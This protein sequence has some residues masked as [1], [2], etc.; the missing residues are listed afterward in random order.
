MVTDL[1]GIGNVLTDAAIHTL[2]KEEILQL[3][4]DID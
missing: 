4:P 2:D 3:N 1:Q